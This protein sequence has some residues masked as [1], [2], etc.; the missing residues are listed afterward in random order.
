MAIAVA[1]AGERLL[2]DAVA[3]RLCNAEQ[4]IVPMHDVVT[5]KTAARNLGSRLAIG[6]LVGE[7]VANAERDR[8]RF[9]DALLTGLVVAHN[10]PWA[11]RAEDGNASGALAH[12]ACTALQ[13]WNPATRVASGRASMINITLPA[14]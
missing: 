1:L 6:I 9:D 8:S 2:D 14:E 13:V 4:P 3:K 11:H 5:V 7:H 12:V 10:C